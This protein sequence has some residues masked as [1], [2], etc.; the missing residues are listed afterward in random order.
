VYYKELTLLG[1]RAFVAGDFP[2]AIRLV[3]DGLIDLDGLITASYPLARVATAFEAYERD[4]E[5]VL[6]IVIVPE[7]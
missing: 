7:G 6:R 1:S 4:P 2:P 3:A 5:R